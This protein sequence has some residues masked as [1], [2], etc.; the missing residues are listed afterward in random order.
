M[1][2]PNWEQV[3]VIVRLSR[4]TRTTVWAE[5]AQ[6]PPP[7]ALPCVVGAKAAPSFRIVTVFAATWMIAHVRPPIEPPFERTAQIV[8]GVVPSITNA[9]T[10][11]II[12]SSP[13]PEPKRVVSS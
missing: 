7:P 9:T 11:P 2:V 6:P 4:F 1:S 12:S 13:F 5:V 10:T 3:A 8:V